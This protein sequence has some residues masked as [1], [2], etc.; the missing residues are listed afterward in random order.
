MARLSRY[1]NN[2]RYRLGRWLVRPEAEHVINH[3]LHVAEQ[4]ATDNRTKE[5]LRYIAIGA[6]YV[7]YGWPGHDQSG[8]EGR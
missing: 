3:Y 4:E 8:Q 2:A 1:A 6:K 5:R 7:A